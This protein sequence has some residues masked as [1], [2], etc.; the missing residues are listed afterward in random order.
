M[1]T[2]QRH[3]HQANLARLAAEDEGAQTVVFPEALRAREASDARVAELMA[4]QRELFRTRRERLA[5][6]REMLRE[7]ID[8]IAEEIRGL[9][10]QVVSASRQLEIIAEEIADKAGLVRRNL[11]PK[12]EL[13][14]LQRIEA[15]ILGDRGDYEAQIA[16]AKQQISEAELRL[17][18]LA[19]ERAAENAEE[20]DRRLGELAEIEEQLAEGE[21]VLERTV[22]TAPVAGTVHDL[23]FK[24][25]GGVVRPSDEIMRIVPADDE[26]LIEAR[27]APND[28]DVV[29]VGMTAEVQLS[30][31]SNRTTPRIT[32]V[33]RSVAPDR[34]VDED[35]GQAFYL[36]RV[37]VD[38]AVLAER[39]GDTAQLVPGM[40]AQVLIVSTERT[41]LN[42]L[43]KPLLDAF[44]RSF[45]EA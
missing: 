43:V 41:L 25:I 9:E 1:L 40:P 24:T 39:L 12:P 29:E 3:A 44:Q 45:R 36:A 35:T 23:R 21:D 37:E 2:A 8:Q 32:G 5:A 30:A 17:V 26:L 19:A 38:R 4:S 10:S 18:T 22:I 28:I 15:S 11:M 31:F 16:R 6:E 42:Y 27:V 33:V 14:A 13:L 7:S 34:S 20:R